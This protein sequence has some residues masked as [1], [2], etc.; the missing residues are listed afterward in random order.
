MIK[1]WPLVSSETL[2]DFRIFKL[3]RDRARHPTAGAE[4]PFFVI[5][6]VD[7][8]NVLPVTADN[9]IVLVRQFRHG[10][11]EVMLEVPGGMVDPGEKP[12][13]A[14]RR[15]LREETGYTCDEIVPLGWV[16]PNPAVQNNRCFSFLARGARYEGPA[17]PEPS[18]ELSVERVPLAGAEQLVRE[19]RITHALVVCAFY[20]LKTR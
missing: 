18:E 16:H 5:E 1:P 12:E 9:E 7:W 8:V 2:A 11:R 6:T 19:G 13:D 14:A 3:R 4:H 20:W 17:N 15:E 10:V